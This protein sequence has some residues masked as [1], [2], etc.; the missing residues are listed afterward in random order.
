MIRH[1]ELFRAFRTGIT[2]QALVLLYQDINEFCH[3]DLFR[4]TFEC[5]YPGDRDPRWCWNDE[6]RLDQGREHAGVSPGVA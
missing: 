4:R 1:G 6:P 3:V 2:R 5:A